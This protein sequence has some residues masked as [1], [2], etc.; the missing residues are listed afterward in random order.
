M[1]P[2]CCTDPYFTFRSERSPNKSLREELLLGRG[3]G[4]LPI[5]TILLGNPFPVARKALATQ[6]AVSY[7]TRRCV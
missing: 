7:K 2:L 4:W 1:R 6:V 5:C 3:G